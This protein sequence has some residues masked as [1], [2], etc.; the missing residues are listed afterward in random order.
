MSATPLQATGPVRLH[1]FAPGGHEALVAA[2]ANLP[3][4]TVTSHVSPGAALEAAQAERGGVLVLENAGTFDLVELLIRVSETASSLPGIVIGENIPILAV[5]RL[6][7]LQRWDMLPPPIAP[8]SLIEA[9]ELVCKQDSSGADS[10]SGKCWTVTSS[11]GGAGAT[12]VAVELAYQLSQRETRGKVC[13]I[14]LDF[15]D[16]ACASYLNCPAN[17]NQSALTQSADRID[18]ALLQAFITHHKNGIDLLA[19]PRSHRLWNAIKPESILK[20]LEVACSLYDHVIVDLPRWPSPWMASVVTG[21]DENIVMSELTV[22]ALHAARSRAE[23]LE[24]ASEGIVQPRIVLN[25]MS[26]KLFGGTVTV[27]QAEEAIGRPVFATIVSEWEAALA[28]VNF[29]QAVSEAKPGNRLTKD[30]SRLIDL[31]EAGNDPMVQ[32]PP[33]KK[34]A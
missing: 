3:T 5:K 11:V 15:F 7:S 27:A 34:K 8:A 20:M 28:A 33:R 26:K 18:E 23:D 21:A 9:L 17:L 4:V 6:M 29:G 1:V 24:D 12:L 25:R 2:S 13:L 22:P 32:S 19:A 16:G 10:A 30:I 31:L 14:D